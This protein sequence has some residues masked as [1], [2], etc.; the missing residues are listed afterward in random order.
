MDVAAKLDAIAQHLRD[1]G[2]QEARELAAGVL[3]AI[4]ASPQA[5]RELSCAAILERAKDPH[6]TVGAY[7]GLLGG[8][9][10]EQGHLDPTPLA[11]AIVGP[12][13]KAVDAAR[14]FV[15]MASECPDEG[16]SEGSMPVGDC[17]L[18]L[19][20]L[21]RLAGRDELAAAAF[22][23]LDVWYRPAAAAWAR[24]P[25]VLRA[26][27]QNPRFREALDACRRANQGTFWLSLL[28]DV[29]LDAP[30][31]VLVPEIEQA[32]AIRV[33]GVADMGQLSILLSDALHE[34][35]SRIGSPAVAPPSVLAT[36]R[37]EGPQQGKGSFGASFHLYPWRAINPSTGFPENGR[38]TWCAPGGVGD[39][40]LPADFQPAAIEPLAGARVL[41]LV[42][43]KALEGVR[44]TRELSAMR[45]F[46]ALR[47]S[48]DGVRR[49]RADEALR[50]R[51][52]VAAALG[53]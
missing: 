21:R 38:F 35:L 14:R 20:T 36:M 9:L 49:L 51:Q 5:Q 23:S 34:P 17:E 52:H 13:A 26:V 31:V 4:G 28:A 6:P 16:P 30:F 45:M 37:G 33:D 12:I 39:L 47:A 2:G 43:P 46:G 44:F 18:S 25:D 22:T 41:A 11:L 1:G 24:T 3:E 50:W 19:A 15:A 27:Q 10:V 40:S 42:G 48:V 8:A 29:A 32:W 53:S 7:F